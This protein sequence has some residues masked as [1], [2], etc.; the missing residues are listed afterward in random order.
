MNSACENVVLGGVHP[1][2]SERMA[3]V[4]RG[5]WA[6]PLA[7]ASL[8]VSAVVFLSWLGARSAQSTTP[9]VGEPEAELAGLVPVSP[10]EAAGS[11]SGSAAQPEGPDAGSRAAGVLPDGRVVLNA[12]T[13]E[14]LCRLPGIGPARAAK[15]VELRAKLGGFRSVRQLL[16]VRGIGPRTLKRLSPLLVLDAPSAPEKDGG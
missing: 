1:P 7:R 10:V 6:R 3:T 5:P 15:I 9:P 4:A 12:A 13:A 14:D 8:V 16:R 11:S 2:W